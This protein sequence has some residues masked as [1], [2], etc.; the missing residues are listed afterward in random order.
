MTSNAKADGRF[1]KQDFGYVADEDVYICP[2]GER[3]AYHYTNEEGPEADVRIQLGCQ[4]R[5]RVRRL[6]VRRPRGETLSL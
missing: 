4:S 6:T 1:G 2:A 3:L 5:A